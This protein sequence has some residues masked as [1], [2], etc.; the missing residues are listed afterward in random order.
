MIRHQAVSRRIN[1]LAKTKSQSGMRHL[2]TIRHERIRSNLP[3]RYLVAISRADPALTKMPS[4]SSPTSKQAFCVS[5]LT[6]P[7]EGVEAL[8]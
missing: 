5:P 2:R 3:I 4:I 6:N 8:S 7:M 1:M